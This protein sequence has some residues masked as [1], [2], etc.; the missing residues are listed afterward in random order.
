MLGGGRKAQKMIE[1][2]LVF[3]GRLQKYKLYTWCCF[4]KGVE[5]GY[6]EF[7]HRE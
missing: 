1:N 3:L 7:L 6:L 4:L 2:E 5:V